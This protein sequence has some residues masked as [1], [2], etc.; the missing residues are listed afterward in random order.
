MLLKAFLRHWI[1]AS[2]HLY[3][4]SERTRRR[5]RRQREHYDLKRRSRGEGDVCRTACSTTVY[6]LSHSG[7]HGF[8]SRAGTIQSMSISDNSNSI[9]AE[10][11]PFVSYS[12]SNLELGGPVI[13]RCELPVH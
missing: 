10:A 8:A 2:Y 5:S 13:T 3:P 4:D 1:T 7:E 12:T 11:K 9:Q 6:S